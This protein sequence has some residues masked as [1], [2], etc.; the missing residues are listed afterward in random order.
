MAKQKGTKHEYK[1]AERS[2]ASIEQRPGESDIQYYRRLAKVA[3][4]R[5]VRL[6]ELSNKEGYE[7]VLKY[8]YAAAVDDIAHYGGA[9]KKT[10]RFN[11]KPPQDKT[12]FHEKIMD[13]KR[14]LST[15]T[16]LK[17]GIDDT[18]ST[19]AKTIN[20][21]YGT[22]FT[23]EDLADL[24]QS[25]D[26]DKLF[27]AYGSKT[28]MQAIGVLQYTEDQVTGNISN[29]QN[30]KSGDIPKTVALDIMRNPK[31]QRTNLRKNMSKDTREAIRKELKGEL[32]I[33]PNK[34]ST[35]KKR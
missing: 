9:N 10:F 22:N 16:S 7:N 17:G 31:F 35:K 27:K 1:S 15:P 19:R 4:Q 8:A 3:D 29:N 28:V 11:R 25:G 32:G 14:F 30:V 18:Y 5:L 21:R 24:F 2:K 6:E 34:R 33:K 23:W 20:E 13:M 26:A 12:L